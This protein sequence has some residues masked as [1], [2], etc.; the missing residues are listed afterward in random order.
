[1]P[2]GIAVGLFVSGLQGLF[3]QLIPLDFLDGKKLY[4]WN[5]PLWLLTALSTGFLFW[6]VLINDDQ[7]SLDAAGATSTLVALGVVAASLVLSIALWL[8][9]KALGPYEPEGVAAGGE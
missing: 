4:E 8:F 2:E 9:F 5:R 3:F 6:E 7:N 1:V